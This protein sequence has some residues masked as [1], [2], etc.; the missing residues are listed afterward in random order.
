MLRRGTS[1]VGDIFPFRGHPQVVTKFDGTKATPGF[2]QAIAYEVDVKNVTFD[3]LRQ[4]LGDMGMSMSENTIHLWCLTE[5]IGS[6][7]STN[8]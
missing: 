8:T 5:N 7:L 6:K 4:W 2:L 3:L 1:R